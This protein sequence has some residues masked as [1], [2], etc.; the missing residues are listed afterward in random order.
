MP[1]PE[2]F[3]PNERALIA[4]A[5]KYMELRAGRAHQGHARSTSRSSAAAPTAACRDFERWRS[6]VQGQAGQRRREALVVPGSQEV[7]KAAEPKASTRSS[8]AA[9]FEWREP[10]LLDVPGR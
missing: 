8:R 9:G 3:P 4:E 1:A 7:R 10:G 6:I 5:L 2:P